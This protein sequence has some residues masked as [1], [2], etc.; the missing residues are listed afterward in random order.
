MKIHPNASRLAA[1]L[2]VVM[3]T[4][5]EAPAQ[6]APE[7]DDGAVSSSLMV[8]AA[9]EPAAPNEEYEPHAL[10]TVSLFAL[11]PAEARIFHEHDLIQIIV[12]ETSSANSLQEMETNKDTNLVITPN[13]WP[14]FQ[15][16]DL[17][18]FVIESGDPT[19]YASIDFETGNAFK[20]DGEYRRRDDFTA[21]LT[22]EVVEILPNGN[23][24]LES[25]TRI[26]TDQEEQLLRVT[27][28]CRP[29]DITPANTVLSSQL[30]DLRIDKEHEGELKKASEPGLFTKIL[31]TL[32]AF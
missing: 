17:L 19:S 1:L 2:A 20:G 32:F 15:V 26:K 12:R 11:A 28:I 24:I 13:E 5:G 3:C 10:R 4:G 22:A 31:N 27:G 9:S 6:Q 23:L 29:E 7:E 8:K 14:N 18:N 21:R 16:A 25:R 30:H